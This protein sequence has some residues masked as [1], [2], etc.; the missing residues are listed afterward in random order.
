MQGLKNLWTHS[1]EHN[2]RNPRQKRDFKNTDINID[3]YLIV[4]HCTQL[5]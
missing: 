2:N 5:N 4:H 3:I 1:Q